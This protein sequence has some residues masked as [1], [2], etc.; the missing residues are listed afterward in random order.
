LAAAAASCASARARR[1]GVRL[2]Q[3]VAQAVQLCS[4]FALLGRSLRFFARKLVERGAF[5][6]SGRRRCRRRLLCVRARLRQLVAQAVQL[7]AGFALLGRS[8]HF[9]AREFI[10]RGAGAFP[11]RR[12]RR[13]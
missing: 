9:F 3:L 2:R 7:C 12:G 10:E 8:L 1:L 6:I 4:G 11:R 5:P 13:R